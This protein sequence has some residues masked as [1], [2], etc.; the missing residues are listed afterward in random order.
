MEAVCARLND[1][2]HNV[3]R[4]QGAAGPDRQSVEQ[5]REHWPSLGPSLTA[6]LLRGEYTP[7]AIRRVWGPMIPKP[8]FSRTGRFSR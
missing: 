5:V 7:G 2:L 3:Y 4:N 8:G 1:A 6:A